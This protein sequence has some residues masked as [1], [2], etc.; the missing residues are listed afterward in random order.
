LRYLA[1]ALDRPQF[2]FWSWAHRGLSAG[3]WLASLVI[4]SP[5]ELC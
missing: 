2:S 5:F 3:G 1:T 4:T